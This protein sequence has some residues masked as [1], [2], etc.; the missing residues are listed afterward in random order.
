MFDVTLTDR[1]GNVAATDDRTLTYAFVGDGEILGIENG[2]RDDLTSYK[3]TYRATWRGRA[4]VYVRARGDGRLF[5]FEK[6]GRLKAE[7]EI[8]KE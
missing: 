7:E 5:V 8:R 1:G 2:R 4:V 3:E 6:G